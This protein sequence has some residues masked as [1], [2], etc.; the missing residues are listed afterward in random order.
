MRAGGSLQSVQPSPPCTAKDHAVEEEV[1]EKVEAAPE[2]PIEK[3][4]GKV[5]TA[6]GVRDLRSKILQ[7]GF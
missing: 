5:R 2:P 4:P 6:R 3:A 7:R 1:E